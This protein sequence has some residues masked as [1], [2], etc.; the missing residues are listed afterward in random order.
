MHHACFVPT[1]LFFVYTLR[2]FYTFS[3]TNLLTTCRSANCLFS[4]VFGFKKAIK[5]IF[6]EL[7]GIKAEVNIFPGTTRRPKGRR[8]RA[9]RRPHHRVARAYPRPLQPMVWTP[10]GSTDLALS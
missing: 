5:E 10:R 2:H 3:G 9:T 8:R 4:I 1:I 6:S 7:D